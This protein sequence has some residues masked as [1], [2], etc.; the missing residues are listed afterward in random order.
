MLLEVAYDGTPFSGFA[1]QPDARTVAGELD[2][3]VRAI[4]P[5]ASLVRGASR[6]DAGVHARGQPVAFD[7]EREIDPRGW[8]LA[9]AAH[10]P[11]EIAVVSAARVPAGYDPRSHAVHKTYRYLVLRSA[12]RDPLLAHRAWRVTDR[13][14]HGLMRAEA[15]ALVGSHDFG[16]FRAAADEREN[17]AREIFQADARVDACDPRLLVVEVRGNRFLYKMM[18]IIVGTLVDVGRGRRAAGAVQR[19]LAS[20]SRDELGMTAPA[21]GLYLHHVELDDSGADRWPPDPRVATLTRGPR[22]A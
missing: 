6:T 9:L 3:A 19:A 4:D 11:D 20:G 8:A 12:V 1:R 17:S 5:R 16:A 13:L 2:G 10:L 7:A 14:N 15:R 22:L 18:R 21:E